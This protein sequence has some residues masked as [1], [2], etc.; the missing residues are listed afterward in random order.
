MPGV[1]P[2]ANNDKRSDAVPLLMDQVV[3]GSTI[4][5][6]SDF[7]PACGDALESA[8][9]DCWYRIDGFNSD[10][11]VTTCPP[12]IGPFNTPF[13]TQV[14]VFV[15]NTSG[16]L[17]KSS[18]CVTGN[19]DDK[20]DTCSWK[21][22][23][24]FYA[25]E[26]FKYYLLVHGYRD[27]A[28]EFAIQATHGKSNDHC[29]DALPLTVGQTVQGTTVGMTGE[30]EPACGGASASNDA[31]VWYTLHGNN[32][33]VEITSCTD[34]T[35]LNSKYWYDTQISVFSGKCG[36]LVCVG[37]NDDMPSSSGSSNSCGT[38]SSVRFRAE[39]RT[40]YYIVVHGFN[41]FKGQFALQVK[42]YK[43]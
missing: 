14:S 6:T 15:G 43:S 9:H 33:E 39:R 12:D 11:S 40:T 17:L 28:G 26:G 20:K 10:V 24:N 8:Y 30:G 34:N 21:S 36:H 16:K 27:F 7:A 41:G 4:G 3:W 35:D 5:K 38:K 31:D 13:D 18:S 37:G 19:D 42:P 29:E 22:G 25:A 32:E 23:V 1:R 2:S